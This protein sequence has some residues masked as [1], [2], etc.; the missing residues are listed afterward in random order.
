VSDLLHVRRRIFPLSLLLLAM[1]ACTAEPAPTRA[2]AQGIAGGKLDA[3]HSSVFFLLSHHATGDAGASQVSLCTA[4][5]IAPNLLVTARHCVSR[6]VVEAVMCGLAP[7]GSPFSASSFLATNAT[8]AA[9]TNAKYYAAAAVGVPVEGNDTCGFDIALITLSE[10]VPASVAVPAIPRIDRDVMQG[11]VYTA[12]GYGED[13]AGNDSVMRMQLSGL[14]VACSPGTCG[15]G[16]ESTEFMGERG[17]CSGDSGGPALDSAGKVVGVVSRGGLMCSTPVYGTVTVWKD[18]IIETA[19]Q[20]AQAGGYT[21]PFWVLSGRSD[22]PEPDAGAAGA[23]AGSPVESDAAAPDAA[24]P[25][26]GGQGATCR[27][28]GDCAPGFGCF[29]PTG[30]TSDAFCAG[31]CSSG[32]ACSEGSTC[33]ARTQ[34]CL[35]AQAPLKL[36]SS[37]ATSPGPSHSGWGGLVAL[38]L[39]G[40]ARAR[41]QSHRARPP[42]A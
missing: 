31:S 6:D 30:S 7:F 17:V 20:A 41:R 36:E 25:I 35:P 29:S 8:S 40:L 10:N 13:Q 27:A 39:A 19:K 16:V 23:D 11:E 21:P 22:P 5:L 18:W 38:C 15:Q 42:R 14:S 32:A 12:V 9:A 1:G 3:I 4:T 37:C 34:L 28:P 33:E 24:T 2:A 26:A